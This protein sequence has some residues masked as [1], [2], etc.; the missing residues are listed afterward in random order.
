MKIY[1]ITF[2][3][4]KVY[5]GQTT[6]E[7]VK[8]FYGHREYAFKNKDITEFSNGSRIGHAIRKYGLNFDWIQEIDTANSL[9]DLN[10]KETYWISEYDTTNP[11]KGY[12]LN[13]GGGNKLHHKETKKKIG[14]ATKERWKDPEIADRMRK[15]LESGVI[16]MK[17][18]KG[19]QKVERIKYTCSH[20]G[21]EFF[22]REKENRHYCSKTCAGV[23]GFQLASERVHEEYLKRHLTTKDLVHNWVIENREIVENCPLNKISTNLMP[24]L[25]I[26]KIDDWRTL[27]KAVANTQSRKEFLLYLKNYVKMYAEPDGN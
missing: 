10:K 4:K 11:S 22:A 23:G 13:S 8:R 19:K 27:T 20:C 7:L 3:N 16:A 1:K 24:L 5:I 9:E 18:S 15:G 26:T 17:K 21:K 6:Q 14:N 25:K 12:N 2:P